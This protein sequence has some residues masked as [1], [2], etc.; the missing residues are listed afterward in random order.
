MFKCLNMDVGALLQ[1]MGFANAGVGYLPGIELASLDLWFNSEA[2]FLLLSALYTG[3]VHMESKRDA[4]RGKMGS[5]DES[6]NLGFLCGGS[7]IAV[8]EGVFFL[9]AQPFLG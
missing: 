8:G 4:S 1:A 2:A 6:G 9:S 5:S 3:L 7:S